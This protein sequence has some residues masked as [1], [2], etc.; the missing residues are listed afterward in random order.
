M[1]SPID[2]ARY[3]LTRQELRLCCLMASGR[4][5]SQIATEM[6]VK[7]ETVRQY[8][9]RLRAKLGI[10]TRPEAI[11]TFRELGFAQISTKL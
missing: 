6:R 7:V 11:V 9:W 8:E 10:D 4:T 5:A 2:I 1:L 3:G